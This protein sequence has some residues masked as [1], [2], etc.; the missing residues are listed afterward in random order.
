MKKIVCILICLCMASVAWAL[1][2]TNGDFEYQ[3]DSSYNVD[4]AY[5]YD[6]GGPDIGVDQGPFFLAA[7]IGSNIFDSKCVYMG[8]EAN[9]NEDGGNHTYVY[10]SIGIYDG[11][12][13]AV[14]VELDWGLASG[15][16]GG[17]MGVTVMILE[18]DG[19]FVPGEWDGAAH[20]I[21][22]KEGITEIGRGSV[23]RYASPGV[24]MHERF[25]LDIT[26]ATIGNEL[27]LRFNNY[28]AEGGVVAYVQVD[29]VTIS[30]AAVL[31]ES[32]ENGATYVATER[33]SSEND[34]VFNIVD[35][36][37]ISVD[38]LF[39]PENEPN[40][41]TKPQFKIV[42]DRS[43]TPGLNTVTLE[44]ELTEDLKWSTEYFWKI[45]A[46]ES[47]GLGGRTFRSESLLRSFTTIQKGPLLFGVTPNVA[48]VWPGENAVFSVPFSSKADTFQWYKEGDPDEELMNGADYAGVD[49]NSLT[50]LDVQ[51]ADEG[52]YYCV[53]TETATGLTAETLSPGVLF[54][55]ELKAYYPFETSAG[56]YT[57]DI[58]G[59]KDAQLMGGASVVEGTN[60]DSI[61]GGYLSLNNPRGETHTQYASIADALVVNYP[62]ITISCWVKPTI[63]DLDFERHARIFDFGQDAE[64][65]FYLTLLH[66]T[67]EAY[68]EMIRDGD[69]RDT[70]GAGEIGYGTKWLYVVLTIAD[71]PDEEGDTTTFGKIYINGR[72][73]GRDGLYHPSDI[74]KPLNYI[75]KAINTTDSPPNFDGLIDELKIYNY[76]KTAEEIAREYMDVMTSVAFICDMEAYDLADWDYDSNC[77]IDLADLVEITERWLQNYLVYFD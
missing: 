69:G 18:S 11:T 32:P 67:N 23:L 17:D 72:Y 60:P 12:P 52:T 15:K 13:P 9:T 56:G 45:L 58:I 38:V 68:C 2:I 40:L 31:Q 16:A 71:G 1:S 20:E 28:E 76:A 7:T 10:Q 55:K 53:G 14:E 48:G 57:P 70:A 46:Y 66:N 22:G 42:E 50:V 34:L 59:G 64:N 75:G 54:V 8:K 3:T 5:W 24:V 43:V 30:P 33:T 21:Y 73:G 25:Q 77:R 63:L 4:I 74:T 47:D 35:P 49:S 61:F 62:D 19:T 29:N 36:D 65:Y 39:G 27:F 44:T 37:I 51:V 41:S 6:Y 26:G